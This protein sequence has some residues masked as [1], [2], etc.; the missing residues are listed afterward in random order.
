MTITTAK[1][2]PLCALSFILLLVPQLIAA[3]QVQTPNPIAVFMGSE[4]LT[5]SGIQMTRYRFDVFNKDSFSADLFAASP[6]LPPC[7]RNTNASRTWVD[8]YD[9]NGKRL[10]G[11]CALAKPDDLN[12]I[13]FS[14]DSNTI[15]PSW[16][17]VELTDRLT[18]TKYKSNLVET[19]L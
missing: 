1:L 17:Y 15:P 7:G 10:N 14:M 12:G 19:C 8:L 4:Y 11:F 2:R 16:I 13:W 6:T 9:Q 18:N 5:N 3:Q